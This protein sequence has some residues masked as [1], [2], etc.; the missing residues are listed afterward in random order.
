MKVESIWLADLRRDDLEFIEHPAR[1]R[2]PA[3]TDVLII[4][5]VEKIDPRY[6]EHFGMP[7]EVK[8]RI[9]ADA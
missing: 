7:G 9:A 5:P 4:L 8:S 1:E 3:T 2:P 6:F